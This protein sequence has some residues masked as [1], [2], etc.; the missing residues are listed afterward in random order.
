MNCNHKYDPASGEPKGNMHK[1]APC[2]F[3]LQAYVEHLGLDKARL[4]WIENNNLDA[5]STVMDLYFEISNGLDIR[6]A[7]DKAKEQSEV[8]DGNVE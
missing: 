2:P 5:L 6:Q 4:D 7:I 8:D 3:C 1:E